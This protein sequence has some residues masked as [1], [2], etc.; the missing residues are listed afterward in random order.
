VVGVDLGQEEGLVV[1]VLVVEVEEQ[2]QGL[3]CLSMLGIKQIRG[4]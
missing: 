1:A 4:R 3:I 2:N